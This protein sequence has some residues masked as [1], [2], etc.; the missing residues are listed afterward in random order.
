MESEAGGVAQ[1]VEHLASKY[2]T[3]KSKLIITKRRMEGREEMKKRRRERRREEGGREGSIWL[4]V[5]VHTCKP[6]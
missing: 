3:L 5:V 6:N 2:Q 4:G 1:V